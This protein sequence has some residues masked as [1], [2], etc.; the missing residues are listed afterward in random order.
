MKQDGW[1]TN[2]RVDTGE[3]GAGVGGGAGGARG[4]GGRGVGREMNYK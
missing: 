3:A 4:Q 2:T 1:G